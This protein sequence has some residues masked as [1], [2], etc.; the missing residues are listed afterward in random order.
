MDFDAANK[1]RDRRLRRGLLQA[2]HNARNAPRR[3]MYGHALRDVVGGVGMPDQFEDDDHLIRLARDLVNK[4]L[5]GE[6][7]E[8][9]RRGQRL[10]AHHLFLR[11]TD[12]GSDLINEDIPP[13]A[14]VDDERV[15]V[16]D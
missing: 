13:I 7:V 11:V 3:G 1:A 9:L 5:A 8:G 12:K 6:E 2:L 14:G 4:G 10:A 16:K 15:E